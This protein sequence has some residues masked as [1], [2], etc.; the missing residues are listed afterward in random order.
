MQNTRWSDLEYVLAVAGK[1]SVAAA[2]RSLGVNHT[3]V[4]RRI[5]GFEDRQNIRIFQRLRSGY[6]L[7][8]KGEMFLEAA[9]SID[10]VVLELD[11]KVAGAD[12]ALRGTLSITTTDSI[13]PSL[14]E[15]L[16]AL[17]QAYPQMIIDVS[18][19]NARLN[20]DERDADIAIRASNNP[21]P[22]LV[23][24][25]ICELAFSIYA[26]H[27]LDADQGRLPLADRCWLGMN[28]PLTATPF[29]LW[30]EE[31]VHESS[32]VCR[33]NSFIGLHDMAEQGLGH[34]IL[35]RILGDASKHLTRVEAKA[36]KLSTGLWLLSHP[37][38]LRSRRVRAGTDFLYEAL[39][40][41]RDVYEGTQ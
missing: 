21:P 11:R 41:K 26:S 13:F 9:L 38:V 2:A 35:P 15:E 19:T 4:L 33:S 7:T 37:D 28:P 3:T 10:D 18:I 14:A 25:R 6:R 5:Q 16:A 12:T 40:R 34:T 31:T 8:D 39:R 23:G 1:G 32:I 24:R 29:G 17:K 27:D 20:L 30:M 22:H 36:V